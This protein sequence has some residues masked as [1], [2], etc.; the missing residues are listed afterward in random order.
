MTDK[1]KYYKEKFTAKLLALFEAQEQV[2]MLYME[3][4]A[5]YPEAAAL[6]GQRD[7]SLLELRAEAERRFN[8]KNSVAA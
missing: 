1:D 7:P 8:E 6:L 5:E 2:A 3:L 4:C